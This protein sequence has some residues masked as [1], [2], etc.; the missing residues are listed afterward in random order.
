MNNLPEDF[1]RYNTYDKFCAGYINQSKRNCFVAN[2]NI[3]SVILGTTVCKGDSGGG[4][5]VKYEGRYYLTGV[6][7]LSPTAPSGGCDSQQ[8]GLFTKVSAHTEDFILKKVTRY[9]ENYLR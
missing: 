7:S 4:L 2:L 5:V 1:H 8:Y 6:V 9:K 3:L